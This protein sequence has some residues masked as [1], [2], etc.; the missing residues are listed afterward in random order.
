MSTLEHFFK[1]ASGAGSSSSTAVPVFAFLAAQKEVAKETEKIATA[2]K[3]RGSYATIS[4]ELKAKVAKYAVKNGISSPIR[5]FK[6]AQDLDLKESTVRGWVTKY[7]KRLDSLHKEGKPV[8]VSV[9][10]E[11]ILFATCL[12]AA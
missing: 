8:T 5:R 7:Q 12:P 1:P 3:K 10:S 9:L 2:G 11:R 4:E 6:S